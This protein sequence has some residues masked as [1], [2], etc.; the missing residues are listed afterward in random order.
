MLYCLFLFRP[1]ERTSWKRFEIFPKPR[2]E[3]SLHIIRF[4]IS[5]RLLSLCHDRRR[6]GSCYAQIAVDH[7]LHTSRPMGSLGFQHTETVCKRLQTAGSFS[8]SLPLPPPPP[9]S[10]PLLFFSFPQFSS[11]WACSQA[12]A[13]GTFLPALV[14]CT[15]WTNPK[16][17]G[18]G[19]EPLTSRW[20][21]HTVFREDVFCF[22]QALYA[23]TLRIWPE[24]RITVRVKKVLK[25]PLQKITELKAWLSELE[26]WTRVSQGWELD[27]SLFNSLARPWTRMK[28]DETFYQ[29]LL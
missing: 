29:L 18:P 21:I 12:M 15:F 19:P 16:D 11:I 13:L 28:F 14:F 6:S 2:Q 17:I 22:S 20:L 3:P 27:E 1:S 25:R 4:F 9:P 7:P 26:S 23:V 24:L 10:P 5:L 8:L